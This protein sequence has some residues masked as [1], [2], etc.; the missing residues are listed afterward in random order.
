MTT[1][2][3][4]DPPDPDPDNDVDD[5]DE[6]QWEALEGRVKKASRE[7]LDEW[8]TEKEKQAKKAGNTTGDA[9]LSLMNRLLGTGSK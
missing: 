8:F 7:A 3:K 1:K 5:P 4:T 6:A 2:P 9:A